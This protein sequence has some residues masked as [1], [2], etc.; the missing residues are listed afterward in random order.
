VLR[1]LFAVFQVY[2]RDCFA[3][4]AASFIWVIADVQAALILPA[5]WLASAGPG[6]MVAGMGRTELVAYY[7]CT[8]TL[9]Q[10]V[11]CHLM[12]DIAQDMK[13]GF[14]SAQLLRPF[15]YFATTAARNLSWRIAKLL[16][17]VP[18]LPIV[19]LAYGGAAGIR[20]HFGW[21]FWSAALMAHTLSFLAAYSLAMVSLW[22]TEYMS[23]FR[24]YYV[25]E[26]FLSGRLIPLTAMPLWAQTLG[27]YT[28]F[29]YMVS[30]PANVLLGKV[31]DSQ[32]AEGLAIQGAW[33]AFFLVLGPALFRRG[34]RQYSGVGM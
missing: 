8:M 27:K 20:L 26:M 11:I 19:M 9:S 17:F 5:V 29:P 15:D 21:Q 25:P 7:L 30:F 6:G 10:F 34:V 3:Y 18:I 24:L 23:L 16:M 2:V 13:E 33:C 28:H 14:F 32:I 22:T 12:W 31:P 1:K 4:P